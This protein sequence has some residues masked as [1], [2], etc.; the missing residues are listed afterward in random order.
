MFRQI[1][2]KASRFTNVTSEQ[3]CSFS[4][5][6][7][8]SRRSDL[9]Q[10]QLMGN[11]G[12]TPELKMKGHV[13]FPLANHSNFKDK[14]DEFV[15]RTTWLNVVVSKPYLKD[16]VTEYIEKGDQIFV[17]GSI[18]A[19]S[20]QDDETERSI[21]AIYIVADNVISVKS[22]SRP[23]EYQN[24]EEHEPFRQE[25]DSFTSESVEETKSSF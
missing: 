20:Y 7:S 10:V 6:T 24:T 13:S 5:S 22:K 15:H 19:S 16:Y 2:N 17:T 14:N 1:V 21:Q 23:R 12:K 8:K 3:L 11:V 25:E 9:N 4:S 18:R